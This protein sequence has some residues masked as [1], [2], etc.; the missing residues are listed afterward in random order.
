MSN[1]QLERNSHE[2]R[3]LLDDVLPHEPYYNS[4]FQASLEGG[5]A[6]ASAIAD[7]LAS[8]DLTGPGDPALSNLLE[9]A[10][11]LSRFNAPA[12]RIIGVVGDSAAG[13]IIQTFVVLVLTLSSRKKQPYQ[14]PCW[15]V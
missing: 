11:E 5:V 8:R 7:C 3:D 2:E 12:T 14:L 4:D 1:L 10:T 9:N 13:Q 15:R 6:L